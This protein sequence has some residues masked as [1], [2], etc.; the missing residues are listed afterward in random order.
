MQFMMP[1]ILLAGDI[2]QGSS[3]V[4]EQQVATLPI[5]VREAVRRKVYAI[6]RGHQTCRGARSSIQQRIVS[7]RGPHFRPLWRQQSGAFQGQ[8]IQRGPSHE[9]AIV[10]AY[11]QSMPGLDSIF[12]DVEEINTM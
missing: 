5:R 2:P 7:Q 3:A 8:L 4:L 9:A 6:S 12:P 11:L 1:G 10:R